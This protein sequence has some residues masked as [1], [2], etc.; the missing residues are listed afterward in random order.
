MSN[1]FETGPYKD[2]TIRQPAPGLSI[3]QI[4]RDVLAGLAMAGMLARP[5]AEGDE[6]PGFAFIA[7]ASYR[8]ADFMIAEAD[9][10]KEERP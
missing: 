7:E 3:H 10:T 2:F 1:P 6:D 8:M 5:V 9:E 4:R